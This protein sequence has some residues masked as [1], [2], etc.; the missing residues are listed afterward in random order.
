MYMTNTT[1][2]R[3]VMIAADEFPSA[4]EA[5]QDTYAFLRGGRAIQ[6]TDAVGLTH[7]FVVDEDEGHRLETARVSFAY[8]NEA[9][10]ADG[11]DR[12]VTVPVN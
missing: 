9:V 7:F 4:H 5:I 12:V 11:S 1:G 2:D 8:L 6:L 3:R 10:F